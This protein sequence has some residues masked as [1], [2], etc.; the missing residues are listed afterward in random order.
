MEKKEFYIVTPVA[1]DILEKVAIL[2]L[3]RIQLPDVIYV[4]QD[5]EGSV[6]YTVQ[7]GNPHALAA[8]QRVHR[9]LSPF[10]SNVRRS[11]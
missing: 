7:T 4:E 10:V 6:P 5:V 8:I 3:S 9:P 1:A 2:F 11:S